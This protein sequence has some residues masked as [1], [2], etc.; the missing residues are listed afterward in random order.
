MRYPGKIL[1]LFLLLTVSLPSA[2]YLDPGTGSMILQ[3]ILAG[4]A[5]AWLTIKTYWYR[6]QAFFGKKPK[7]GLLDDEPDQKGEDDN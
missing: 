3:G 4:I 6:I 5:V 1:V 2:A 7:A